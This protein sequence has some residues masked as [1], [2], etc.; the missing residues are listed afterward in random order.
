[1]ST[2]IEV[3]KKTKFS[4]SIKEIFSKE[5][6]IKF[7]KSDKFKR[8]CFYFIL[9]VIFLVIANEL[10]SA[11]SPPPSGGG[12]GGG[13][14]GTGSGGTGTNTQATG[15][16]ST[17]TTALGTLVDDFFQ[18][19]MEQLAVMIA[20]LSAVILALCVLLFT[21][22]FLLKLL[23]Q[24]GNIS[25]SSLIGNS[26]S[27]F[28]TFSI[29][30]FLLLP[31]GKKVNMSRK[32]GNITTLTSVEINNYQYIT[33]GTP[34]LQSLSIM[35]GFMDMGKAFYNVDN[36][37]E[38]FDLRKPSDALN[39]VFDIP[40]MLW[41]LSMIDEIG[42]MPTVVYILLTFFSLFTT[43]SLAKD[44]MMAFLSYVLVVGLSVVLMPFLL[45]TK[46]ASIGQQIVN[47]IVNK[48]LSLSIR[49]GLIG[50]VLNIITIA[51]DS[52]GEA[53]EKGNKDAVT[54]GNALQVAFILMIGMFIAGEGGQVASSVL[55]GNVANLSASKF[56]GGSIGKI[57]SLGT[58]VVAGATNLYNK[59][60]DAKDKEAFEKDTKGLDKANEDLN[61]QKQEN[62]GKIDAYTAKEKDKENALNKAD[63][64]Y[65]NAQDKL[66]KA[67]KSGN[68]D[69]INK[70]KKELK[71]A[72]EARKNAKDDLDKTK[73]EN[74]DKV[75]DLKSQNA[76]L[77]KQIDANN[78]TKEKKKEKMEKAIQARAEKRAKA[79][80]GIENKAKSVANAISSGAG[81]TQEFGSAMGAVGVMASVA[82]ATGKIAKSGWKGVQGTATA[83]GQANKFVG[84]FNPN[85]DATVGKQMRAEV[86]KDAKDFAKKYTT[87]VVNNVGDKV[88]GM[89]NAV[90]NVGSDVGGEVKDL[91]KGAGSGLSDLKD[92]VTYGRFA[93][94]DEGKFIKPEDIRQ[95]T[96]R[97]SVEFDNAYRETVQEYINDGRLTGITTYNETVGA[98]GSTVI[99][100]KSYGELRKEIESMGGN[101]KDPKNVDNLKATIISQSILTNA[102]NKY[103]KAQKPAKSYAE[104]KKREN[105]KDFYSGKRE[106]KD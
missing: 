46:T 39:K 7:L 42:F 38:D 15:A 94:D 55:S 27:G 28:I 59:R 93:K 53:I 36:S 37:S 34:D 101:S 21:I 40:F 102:K 75:D 35:T 52:F 70:A 60:K 45:F 87:D 95:D 79:I 41:N 82:G 100:P 89:Y 17:V 98:D 1:M 104:A 81:N 48:G 23:Q 25:I 67:K 10:F 106:T 62:I 20:N 57:A 12:T 2:N 91:F 74:K 50:V 105:E 99:T 30:V 49:L 83:L 56:V 47:N 73:A 4:L 8:I 80:K 77:D 78:E 63:K 71:T 76:D 19:I 54:T 22:D 44:L 61:K 64:D 32:K 26:L 85:I 16:I 3:M 90:K 51:M 103:D 43:I 33:M 13:S 69:E 58:M 96:Y 86:A 5:K 92:R 31:S 72:D 11:P 9:I 68:I 14:G 88:K 84:S 66:D 29:V 65:K 97:A 24:I 6:I 18:K